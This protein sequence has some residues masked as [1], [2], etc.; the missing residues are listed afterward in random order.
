[1]Q[2][3]QVGERASATSLEWDNGLKRPSIFFVDE[4]TASRTFAVLL[5]PESFWEATFL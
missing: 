5:L 1:V 4:L 2:Q 3:F